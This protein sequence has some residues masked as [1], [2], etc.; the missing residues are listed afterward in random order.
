MDSDRKLTLAN[1]LDHHQ[2]SLYDLYGRSANRSFSRL[3]VEADLK[4]DF[5]VENEEEVVK[6]LPYLFHLNSKKLLDFLLKYI[7]QR[8]IGNQQEELMRN[9]LFYT[10]YRATPEKL[11]LLTI[12]EG[13]DRVLS[14]TELKEEI[15]AILEYKLSKIE[16]RSGIMIFTLRHH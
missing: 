2:M 9:L 10:F 11:G 1:F 7:D 16:T 3:L 13:I 6:R 14:S 12:E 8:Q 15:R 4:E 5:Y